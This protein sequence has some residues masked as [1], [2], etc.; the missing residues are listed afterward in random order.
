[1][2]EFAPEPSPENLPPSLPPAPTNY[3]AGDPAGDPQQNNDP[4]PKGDSQQDKENAPNGEELS[5]EELPNRRRFFKRLLGATATGAEAAFILSP[6]YIGD[7]RSM[8]R[9]AEDIAKFKRGGPYPCQDET[10]VLPGGQEIR[11]LGVLHSE[12]HFAYSRDHIEKAIREA[13]V[14]LLEGPVAGIGFRRSYFSERAEYALAHG[15][16]VYDIDTFDRVKLMTGWNEWRKF[17]AVFGGVGLG[18]EATRQAGED[19]NKAG[20]LRRTAMRILGYFGAL[21]AFPSSTSTVSEAIAPKSY[22]AADVGFVTDARTVFMIDNAIE[23]AKA[24]PGAK[25]LVMSGDLHAKGFS[26][27]LSNSS[28]RALLDAKRAL[29]RQLYGDSFKHHYEKID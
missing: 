6:L 23:I 1:M 2:S 9:Y 12:E 18:L 5:G 19:W 24:H 28:T 27:Y 4:E 25:I 7:E 20:M 8:A 14:V 22:P 11:N 10:V 17:A 29:H 26:Y 3:P 16:E 15:K 21:T 13:D